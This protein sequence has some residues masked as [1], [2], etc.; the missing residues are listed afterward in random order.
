MDRRLPII[1]MTAAALAG[2]SEL[3]LDAGTHDFMAKPVKLEDL[4]A[5][6]VK[7]APASEAIRSEGL[8]PAVARETYQAFAP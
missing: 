2:S 4:V 6:L 7:W 3:C 1:A 8:L 5:A